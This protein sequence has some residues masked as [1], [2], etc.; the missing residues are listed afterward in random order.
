M[1][2]MIASDIHGSAHYC[3]KMIDAYRRE[4]AEKLLLLGDILYHG[5]RND[6]PKEYNPKQVIAMLNE[7]SSELL[8]VRGNCDTEV[9]QMVLDFPIMA[10]YCILYMEH[11][12]IFA[13]HGH[14]FNEENPP[15]LKKGDILLNGHTHIPKCIEHENYIYMNPGSISIP[16]SESSTGYMIVE[17]N[18]FLWKDLDGNCFDIFKFK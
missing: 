1:K 3:Q 17:K 8:C 5:P 4:N 15:L 18:E 11:H 12:M 14:K 9:D 2:I 10:E 7:I 13:T 6:L 16:K